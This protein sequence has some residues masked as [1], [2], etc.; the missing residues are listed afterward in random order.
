MKIAIATDDGNTL[1]QHFGRATHY[2]VATIEGGQVT[3]QEMRPKVGHAHVGGSHGAHQTGQPHGFDA[4]A[5]N[6]HA[7][8]IKAI[9]DCQTVLCGGMGNG[10]YQ[11]LKR[12]GIEPI[13]TDIRTIPEAIKAYVDGQIVNRVDRLH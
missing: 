11:S 3:N 10:A 2:L 12:H 7:R 6:H 5:Q 9:P 13:I 4:E 1:S 8:M